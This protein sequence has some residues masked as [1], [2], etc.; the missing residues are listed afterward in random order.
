MRTVSLLEDPGGTGSITD[1]GSEGFS[2]ATLRRDGGLR[3]E[4]CVPRAHS[5]DRALVADAAGDAAVVRLR[6]EIDVADCR[7]L[8]RRLRG[9]TG[10]IVVDLTHVTLLS[11]AAIGV[12]IAHAERL[13][14]ADG[15]LLVAAGTPDIRRLLRVIQ[16]DT[17]LRT[18][19]GLPQA[20][21]ASQIPAGQESPP[22][23]GRRRVD[24]RGGADRALRRR[25]R[26][27]P[28]VARA[29]G[30]LQERYG[31]ANADVAFDVLRLS[32][33]RHNLRLHLVA[34]VFLAAPAPERPQDE[35]WFPGRLR[36]V[37]PRLTFADRSVSSS[38][39]RTAVL[40]AVLDAMMA[41]LDTEIAHLLMIEIRQG[42]LCLERHRGLTA[43]YLEFIDSGRAPLTVPTLAVRRRAR[44]VIADVA[45]DPVFT[46]GGERLVLLAAGSRAIQSSPLLAASGEPVGV[47]TTGHLRRGR[48]P[49]VA[50]HARLDRI[51]A[52]AGAWLE[53]HRRTVVLDALEQVHQSAR[54]VGGL[55][56]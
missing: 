45:A 53:W 3:R 48:V 17:V 50:E 42:A 32:S 10:R 43:E 8:D 11:A 27:Q 18:Y 36:R 26:T 34:A 56:P 47:A 12:L 39:N 55:A 51:C 44:V 23:R 9:H 25:L 30:V 46:D 2:S 15:A 13:A 5:D 52:E 31:L 38:G 33:Q 35:V 29:M 21:E 4:S 6:G 41:C 1:E 49:T 14:D 20:M 19:D 7:A 28:T 16:A 22:Y 54:S 40:D 24:L 37:A